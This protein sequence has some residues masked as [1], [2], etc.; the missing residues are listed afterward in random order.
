MA[1]AGVLIAMVQV[2]ELRDVLQRWGYETY[3]LRKEDL[4]HRMHLAITEED[5]KYVP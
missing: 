1:P 3:G 4:V 2:Q 5:D